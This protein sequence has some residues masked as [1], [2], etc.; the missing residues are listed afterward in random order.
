MPR[1]S[2]TASGARGGRTGWGGMGAS[3]AEDGVHEEQEQ[4]GIAGRSR[5]GRV[6]C[7]S[8]RRWGGA[9]LVMKSCRCGF[10]VACNQR[11]LGRC[12]ASGWAANRHRHAEPRSGREERGKPTLERCLVLLG[13][14][15]IVTHR[16]PGELASLF[17]VARARSRRS[18]CVYHASA[19][20]GCCTKPSFTPDCSTNL[21]IAAVEL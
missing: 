21:G 2:C 10:G 16:R 9:C 20:D 7:G 19:T 12:K 5:D 17:T 18:S 1:G 14:R 6:T 3:V 8:V 15:I 11:T 13:Q 4:A